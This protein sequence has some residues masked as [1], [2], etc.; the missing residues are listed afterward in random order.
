MKLFRKLPADARAKS[1]DLYFLTQGDYAA[2]EFDEAQRDVIQPKH[3]RSAV[4]ALFAKGNFAA[5]FVHSV[6]AA[7]ERTITRPS[8]S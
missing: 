3:C 1:Q 7:F 8:R 5:V 2:F 6:G 4:T